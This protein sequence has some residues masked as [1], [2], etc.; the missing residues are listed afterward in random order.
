ML[1]YGAIELLAKLRVDDSLAVWGVHGI[2]G[3]WGALATGLFVGVGFG[4]LAD[5]VS[6]IEQV[7][8]Q[9]VGIGATW[10]WSFVM[11]AGIL[12]AIKYA[13]GLRVS[14]EEER[15]G[16]DE[17]LHG[18]PAYVEDEPLAQPATVAAMAAGGNGDGAGDD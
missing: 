11:T 6:R 8:Y 13:I 5:G 3:T 9:L 7:G 12:L 16:L 1:C 15:A 18:E 17:A 10:V 14:E 2:G 4:A